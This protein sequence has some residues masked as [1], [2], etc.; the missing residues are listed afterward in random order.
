VFGRDALEELVSS[1]DDR[2]LVEVWSAA[3][4]GDAKAW[5][6]PRQQL[7]GVWDRGV[8]RRRQDYSLTET[9]MPRVDLSCPC[10]GSGLVHAEVATWRGTL[11]Q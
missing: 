4:D 3:L 10:A 8:F 11:T 9:V 6:V 7:V 5:W 1:D 2:C